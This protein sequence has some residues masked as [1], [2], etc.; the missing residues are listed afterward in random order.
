MKRDDMNNHEISIEKRRDAWAKFNRVADDVRELYPDI[1]FTAQEYRKHFK[2][3]GDYVFFL[4]CQEKTGIR[5][6]QKASGFPYLTLAMTPPGRMDEKGG[7]R[8]FPVEAK[9][10]I[11]AAVFSSFQHK[12]RPVAC[13]WSPGSGG[14][15]NKPLFRFHNAYLK[16]IRGA[17]EKHPGLVRFDFE[18]VIDQLLSI[19]NE[20]RIL[21]LQAADEG[22][23]AVL[24]AML[25]DLEQVTKRM[26]HG[27]RELVPTAGHY[28]ALVDR[29]RAMDNT[30]A[31]KVGEVAG[32]MGAQQNYS[33]GQSE[34]RKT[35]QRERREILA[36]Y[37][38][39]AE[40]DREKCITALMDK[41]LIRKDAHRP[42]PY[43]RK[44]WR[45]AGVPEHPLAVSI[46]TIEAD[47]KALEGA[48]PPYRPRKK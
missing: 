13:S 12:Q 11:E 18:T 25:A 41:G 15:E 3:L 35:R 44:H 20:K 47:I 23:P 7:W 1:V 5:A 36:P 29:I 40:G 8:H 31:I 26:E 22:L 39:A 48:K 37:V 38:A 27:D 21:A 19:E 24:L 45:P 30:L 9:K 43:G 6:N 34:N 33:R 4:Y 2:R 10:Q 42:P 28:H 46:Q 16:Q 17:Q 14:T 32:A